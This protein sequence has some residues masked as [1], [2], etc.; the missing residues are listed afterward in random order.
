MQF[1]EATSLDSN[2]RQPV[3]HALYTREEDVVSSSSFRLPKPWPYVWLFSTSSSSICG[4]SAHTWL[5][6]LAAS[7]NVLV[8]SWFLSLFLSLSQEKKISLVS[9]ETEINKTCSLFSSP[10]N[11]I[12]D[13]NM[14]FP[15][16][17]PQCLRA[18]TH[19]QKE[20]CTVENNVLHILP[21]ISKNVPSHKNVLK[22]QYCPRDC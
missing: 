4:H 6:F 20:N 3:S 21:W 17:L 15:Q 7:W 22:Q 12:W 10:Y 16:P 2:Y 9:N 14:D 11:I 18:R 13:G 5:F 1:Q 8:C 19:T